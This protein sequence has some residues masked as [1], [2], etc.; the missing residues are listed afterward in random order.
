MSIKDITNYVRQTPGNT[1]PNVIRSMVEA[2]VGEYVDEAANEALRKLGI[3]EEK[4]KNVYFPEQIFICD[5]EGYYE[6]SFYP[7][8]GKTYTVLV[9]GTEY[10]TK[11]IIATIE[12]EDICLGN[13]G[14]LGLGFEDTGEPWAILHYPGASFSL[15][16]WIDGTAQEI[17]L[18]IYEETETI[19]SIDPKYLPEGGVGWEEPGKVLM[20]NENAH[21]ETLDNLIFAKI[22]DTNVN[23]ANVKSVRAVYAGNVAELSGDSLTLV[24]TGGVTALV[25]NESLVLAFNI[26]SGETFGTMTQGVWILYNNEQNCVQQI[27]VAETIHPIDQKY[28]PSGSGLPAVVL[29]TALKID[30]FVTLS[31]AD[32]EKLDAVP[33]ESP[34]IIYISFP[35]KGMYVNTAFTYIYYNNTDAYMG[36]IPLGS[37]IISVSVFK[38]ENAWSAHCVILGSL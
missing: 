2:Q 5:E 25:G 36:M 4:S 31:E 9:N 10:K 3:R 6:L 21:T 17:T 12:G 32:C 18:S 15:F 7:E 16:V 33:Y 29:E 1:N 35:D 34:A 14:G 28:L 19:T 24:E 38:S 20:Y 11:A 8:A 30:E 13:I 22:S 27:T 26:S 23:L 37:G